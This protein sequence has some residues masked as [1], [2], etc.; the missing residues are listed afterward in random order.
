MTST[1]LGQR[2][3][4]DRTD[5]VVWDPTFRMGGGVLLGDAGEVSIVAV[6]RCTSF[7]FHALL[8]TANIL[9]CDP[10]QDKVQYFILSR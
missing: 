3:D 8:Q 6:E 1:Y 10:L 4:F 5:N 7:E 9:P 2:T